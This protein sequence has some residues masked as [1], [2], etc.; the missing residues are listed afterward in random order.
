MDINSA[1]SRLRAMRFLGRNEYIKIKTIYLDLSQKAIN[2]WLY[3]GVIPFS[4]KKYGVRV[5]LFEMDTYV[6]NDDSESFLMVRERILV[7]LIKKANK[8]KSERLRIKRERI[9]ERNRLH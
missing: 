6:G 8:N 1:T 4:T 3:T 7:K 9:V 2:S 5:D